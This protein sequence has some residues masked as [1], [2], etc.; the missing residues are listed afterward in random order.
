MINSQSLRGALAF[1]VVAVL[2][3]FVRNFGEYISPCGVAVISNSTVC[4]VCGFEPTAFGV[5]RK[6]VQ[7]FV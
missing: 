5:K 7:F 6:L 3:F 1:A 4:D 2:L